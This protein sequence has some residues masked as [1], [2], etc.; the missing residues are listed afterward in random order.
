MAYTTLTFEQVIE[1]MNT[2]EQT[3]GMSVLEHGQLVNLYYQDLMTHLETGA[4]LMY[5]W[6]LPEWVYNYKDT[7]LQLVYPPSIINVY[8]KMHDLGKPYCKIIDDN[9]KQHF[10]DHA[11]KSYEVWNHIFKNEPNAEIIGNLIKMDMDIHVLKSE[12][13]DEF[14]KRREAVTLLVSGL[15]EIHANSSMFG[16]IQ[17]ISFK[18]KQKHI[19]KR[20]EKILQLIRSNLA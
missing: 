4:P 17:S 19:K 11:N 12:H 14:A 9:G 2:C 6:R 7:I 3:Q 5:Q 15:A 18:I 10:P 8:L 13:V 16:G 1:D 20:G